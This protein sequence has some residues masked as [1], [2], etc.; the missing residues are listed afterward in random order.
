MTD[1]FNKWD[2]G[3]ALARDVL[4]AMVTDDAA[5]DGAYLDGIA[6]ILRDDRLDPAFRALA[7]SLPSEDDMAQALFD[8]GTTPNPD[9]IHLATEAFKVAVAQHCQDILPRI[10]A[11]CVVAG[12]YSPDAKSAGKRSL[13]RTALALISRLDGGAAAAKTYADADNMTM[14][15]AGL[16]ALLMIGKGADESDAFR[17]QWRQDRLVMD[18]W[19]ALAVSMAP[20][21]HA[22]MVAQAL[23]Q[24]P[25]FDMKNPNRFRAVF[26]A[27][28][29]NAAG[30]HN[31]TGASYTLLG[32]WLGKL[33]QVNPQTTAR[34]TTAFATWKRYD[35]D[36]Q[37]KIKA[38]LGGLLAKP[39]LSRDT[40]EMVARML[41][42]ST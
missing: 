15:L 7:L 10:M 40:R 34:M 41:E 24:E 39:G 3:R 12:P 28:A 26:G 42:K 1:P 6:S 5:P 17:T 4:S 29:G 21:E 14:Q 20:P 38:V 31:S 33:D 19:F 18:K 13:G 30:F 27:L 32:D 8:A 25:D 9:N 36:R 23:T 37:D 16:S 35:T 11:D 22:A 2:A